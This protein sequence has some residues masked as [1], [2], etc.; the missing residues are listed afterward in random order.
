[1]PDVYNRATQFGGAISSDGTKVTF[2]D[3]K[4]GFL[5]QT[6]QINYAQ[7]VTRIFELA[8]NTQYY[9]V[10]RPQGTIAMARIVGPRGANLAFVTKFGDACK[11]N[12]NTL[13][14]SGNAGCGDAA[15]GAF[16]FTAFNVLMTQMGLAI[17][18][19]DMLINENFQLMFVGLEGGGSS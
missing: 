16:R 11:A 6:L 2:D 19:Q 7:N 13:E 1:M 17:S 12:E 10:G 14:L 5:A 9:V 18:A 8:S 15:Q 4:T 3:F